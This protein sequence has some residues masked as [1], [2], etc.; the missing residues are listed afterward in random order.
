M[1]RLVRGSTVAIVAL[2][3]LTACASAFEVRW[4]TYDQG[5]RSAIL[6]ATALRDCRAL[7]GLRAFAELSSATHQRSTGYPNDALIAYIEAAQRR[8][9]C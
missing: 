5:L 2:S 7:Q 6:Q 8:A 4:E 1:N 3:L 9:R